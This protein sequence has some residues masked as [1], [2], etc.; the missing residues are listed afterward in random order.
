MTFV[1]S[2]WYFVI[3][4]LVAGVVACIIVFFKMDKKDKEL[5][6]NF[7]EE[8]QNQAQ[9]TVLTEKKSKNNK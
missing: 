5:I 1:F 7:V 6:K 8:S 2:F 3:L 4:A 9:E